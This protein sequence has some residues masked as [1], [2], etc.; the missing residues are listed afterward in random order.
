M[1]ARVHRKEC[2]GAP[3][4]P[5]QLSRN[6]PWRA[7]LVVPQLRVKW[8]FSWYQ[9][10]PALFKVR[11]AMFGSCGDFLRWSSFVFISFTGS[12]RNF[13]G[14][15]TQGNFGLPCYIF[16]NRKLVFRE[17][18]L[19]TLIFPGDFPFK[20]SQVTTMFIIYEFDLI[21]FSW[22]FQCRLSLHQLRRIECWQ[23]KSTN[24]H[25][26]KM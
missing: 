11:W 8:C 6:I 21:P 20:T 2:Q 26:K 18:L 16:E 22:C 10:A 3:A 19:D 25:G 4:W 5:S 13:T 23:V 9:K 7:V 17:Q 14:L 1:Y 24:F 15:T 12:W